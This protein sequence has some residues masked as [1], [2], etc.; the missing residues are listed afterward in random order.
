MTTLALAPTLS[1]SA[2]VPKTAAADHTIEISQDH[3]LYSIDQLIRSR[4][5][6]ENADAPIV[7]Y[8]SSSNEYIY[9]SPKQLD[10]FASRVARHYARWIPQRQTSSDPVQVIGLLGPSDFEYLVTLLAISR[11]GHTVMFLS[12]RISEE[13]YLGLLRTTAATTLLVSRP[14]ES[15]AAKIATRHP[16]AVLPVCSRSDYDGPATSCESTLDSTNLSPEEE[17]KNIAWIIH[18]SG[19][20][21]LPKPIYQ[22]HTGALKNYA[23]NFGLRGFIT[24]PLFHA[25]GISCLFRA[26]HARKLIYMYNAVLP[27]TAPHL[28]STL[29]KHDIQILYAVPYALKL[30]AES[31]KG[32]ELLASLDLVMFGGSACPKPIGDKLASQGVLLV[33]HYGTTET[34]QLMTSFRERSD[35][36]WDFVRPTDNLKPFLRWEEQDKGSG[37]YELVILE[38][39]PSKVASNRPDNAYATKDL[40]EKHP[41]RP[42]AWRYYARLDDTLVLENGEKANPLY[43]E[44]VARENRNIGE[45]VA[46]GANKERLGLFIV[47]SDCTLCTNDDELISTI[48]PA[49]DS[50]NEK[51]PAFSRISRDMIKVLPKTTQYR[52]T[53]KGTVIRAAFYRD[54]SDLIEAAYVDDAVSGELCLQG[55]D[56]TGFLRTHLME[57]TGI[58]D[59]SM[60]QDDTDLFSLGVDSLQSLRLRSIIQKL[61][62]VGGKQLPQNFV[63]ENPTLAAMATELTRLRTGAEKAPQLSLEERMTAL[64]EKYGNFAPYCSGHKWSGKDHIVSAIV[65][66]DEFSQANREQVLT[67]ATGSLGAHILARLCSQDNVAKVYCLVRARSIQTARRRIRQSLQERL[68]YHTMPLYVLDKI[69]ALPA[70][71]SD[72]KLGLAPS[73]YEQISTQV[74]GVIHCAWSVNFNM[75]L[76]SFEKD[77]IAA[78]RYL[79]DLCLTPGRQEPARLAFCSSV[80]AVARTPGSVA[81]EDLPESLLHA[82]NMGYAQSKLVTEHICRRAAAQ[83]GMSARVVRVGQIIADTEHG[84]WNATEAIPMIFQSATTCNALPALDESPSWTPV[85]VIANGVI[86]AL[87]SEAPHG[88]INLTNPSLFHWTNDLLPQLRQAGLSFDTVSQRQWIARLRNSSQDPAANPPIKLLDFFAAKY[89]HDTPGRKLRYETFRAAECAPSLSAATVPSNDLVKKF[90]EYF[91]RQ[92]WIKTQSAMSSVQTLI[93]C[94]GPCGT[95]KTT[96]ARAIAKSLGIPDVKGDELHNESARQQMRNGQP[97]C[98]DDQW[99]WLDRIKSTAQSR[100]VQTKSKAIIVTCSALKAAHRD[101][102]RTLGNQGNFHVRFLLLVGDESELKRRTAIRHEIEGHYVK[103]D[104]VDSQL[105]LLEMPLRREIDI[106]P[107]DCRMS[108]HEVVDLSREIVEDMLAF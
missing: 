44:G 59:V 55:D 2:N 14:F 97:L 29:E 53:D 8:P 41:T 36:D 74:S 56:L 49:V 66:L 25:H 83:T 24:L 67:G 108:K 87:R 58:K 9:Y 71:L 37:I 4:A 65:R 32:V 102:L 79:L 50:S 16:L 88:V 63:F 7:A 11:L 31:D 105:A 106:T 23:N 30:L 13:A 101:A 6:D 80:S 107:L 1:R 68:L 86:E 75:S 42:H 43:V 100:L 77:C 52:K 27:L 64:I 85:N 46:F 70:I 38:G 84:V 39:W 15:T 28:I 91:Q 26:I 47:P 60:L 73:T 95:G 96:V 94:A 34:G 89:D 54:F 17:T 72:Q 81:I 76:E 40:F 5:H 99:E 10:A 19:S 12:T 48:W 18:S 93:V 57:V 33:S 92:C 20:T 62:D 21:G 69:V 3:D 45:A 104:M 61:L 98:E 35:R 90:I 78:T 22:T 51:V 103:A 82:Q